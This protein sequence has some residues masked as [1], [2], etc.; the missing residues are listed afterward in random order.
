[1][2]TVIAQVYSMPLVSIL[3][4]VQVFLAA[5]LASQINQW[6]GRKQKLSSLLQYK[7][8]GLTGALLLLTGPHQYQK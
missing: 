4:M 1:M 3:S 6:M 5:P 8:L 2:A 7:I